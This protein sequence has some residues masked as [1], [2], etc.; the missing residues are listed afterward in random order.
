MWKI[1]LHVLLLTH[2]FPPYIIGG[3]GTFSAELADALGNSGID[4]TVVTGS[5]ARPLR[6]D[7]LGRVNVVR[8]PRID[9][10]PNWLWFQLMNQ[11]AFRK[12]LRNVDIVHGQDTSTFPTIYFAKRKNPK[13][14]WVVT[15]H[16]CPV[17]EMGYTI[18]S[19]YHGGSIHEFVS[20]VV[21]FP[22]WDTILRGDMSFADTIVT[23]SKCLSSELKES[24]YLASNQILTIYPGVNIKRTIETALRDT[25]S[26]TSSK[27]R[28]FF[29]GR[30]VWRKGL[31]HLLRSLE[32]LKQQ[33]GFVDFELNIFG[34]GPLDSTIKQ[35]VTH[36]GLEHQVRLRGFVK[37]NELLMWLASSH[38]VCFPS[39]SEY[40]P[41]AMIEA[42][43]L[44]KPIVAFD[45]PFAR[46]TI[47]EYPKLPLASSVED[48]ARNLY[49]LSTNEGLRGKMGKALQ[50]RARNKFDMS[51][52]AGN[53]ARL[54]NR[55]LN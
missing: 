43:A 14:P 35:L 41:T 36:I 7:R 13:L 10:P 18:E 53:Y 34:R 37:Y 5:P 29:S 46:E 6:T 26:P 47:G 28:M 40:C 32:I 3:V 1:R 55:L 9:I 27:L 50:E 8:V 42:M 19:M 2:E 16:G 25:P 31:V 24:K 48:F 23:V 30:H 44:A 20:C 49:T 54:Y 15:V 39:L 17:S 22:V 11:N 21:G 33:F 52:I 51:I 4:V 12:I 45:K 38:V